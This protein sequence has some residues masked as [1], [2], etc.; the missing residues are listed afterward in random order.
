MPLGVRAQVQF[1][2]SPPEIDSFPVVRSTISV[3]YSGSPA[4]F[5]KSNLSV[6]E[7]GQA[8]TNFE[9]LDCDESDAASIALLV[10]VSESMMFTLWKGS[11]E[12]YN[13]F[14]NFTDQLHA[15][16]EYA[17]IP[18]NDTVSRIIP[19]SYRTQDFFKVG[20]P[21]NL[22]EFIDSI[23]GLQFSGNTDVD[24]AIWR[25]TEHLKRASHSRKAIVLMTD[26]GIYDYPGLVALLKQEGMSLFVL[27]L[28]ADT[29]KGNIVAANE[30]GG[31]FF[32]PR[33]STE[34]GPM[35]TE[36]A[37]AIFAKKCTMRY[38][39]DHPC[40][41]WS[42]KTLWI[43]L[44]YQNEKLAQ[45]HYFSLGPNKRDS[46]APRISE[47]QVGPSSR[48]VRAD[49]DFPCQRG[50]RSFTDSA[51]VNF[52]K[53]SRVR[54]L[55]KFAYDSLVVNDLSQ[56]AEGYYIAT[57]S[58]GNASRIKI[59]YI[60]APDTL[61][62]V[63]SVPFNTAPEQYQLT[64]T[65]FRKHDRGI[66]SIVLEASS[67]NAKLD[68]V[69]YASAR[70]AEV[71]VSRIDY[72]QPATACLIAIDSVGNDSST[73]ITFVVGRSDINPPVIIQ[74]AA[75]SPY[76]AMMADVTELR[77]GD[78]GIRSISVTPISNLSGS[79]IQYKSPFVAEVTAAIADSLYA[80]AAL[81][82][83][84]DSA[85]NSSQK[86][87]VYT[88]LPDVLA[89]AYALDPVNAQR[90]D[91]T[92]SESQ[93]W[94]RGLRSVDVLQSSNISSTQSSFARRVSGWTF[95][96]IDPY[97][98]ATAEVEAQDSAG[99]RTTITITIPAQTPP[100]KLPLSYEDPIDFG[101]VT[102]PALL[103]RSIA[104]ANPD[105]DPVVIA[106]GTWSGDDSIFSVVTPL[107]AAF[108]PGSM[109]NIAFNYRPLLLGDWAATYTIETTNGEKYPIRMKGSSTGLLNLT[110][111]DVA[112]LNA[113]DAGELTLGIEG[114]PDVM[115]LDTLSF[116]L[117]L[118]DDVAKLLRPSTS[119]ADADWFCN[120]S[121]DWS[122]PG[123][124]RYDIRLERKTTERS[125]ELSPSPRLR[126]PF[127]TYLSGKLQT[128]VAVT[129][130][131]ASRATVTSQAGSIA[132][133]ESCGDSI[134]VDRLSKAAT[135]RIE[136]AEV[137]PN[138]E[139]LLGFSS[140]SDQEVTIT[141][142][143]LKG[144]RCFETSRA[145]EQGK[146]LLRMK[147]PD[148]PSGAYQLV[149]TSETGTHRRA[150]HIVH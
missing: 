132:I 148:L 119:C 44:N 69:I 32:S 103:K 29:I 149:I 96:S 121:L 83:A 60:P 137:G 43:G 81:V 7:D 127:K 61:S 136:R 146:N 79:S 88:P 98:I 24:F 15:P 56:P 89:P 87:L 10:D 5:D 122:T 3:E 66:K 50:I 41:W 6:Q 75:V 116:S 147:L 106:G 46:I 104:V 131:F 53:L 71:Y 141:L 139:L 1:F 38:V 125:L 91:L 99:N 25:A 114:T 144:L 4:L 129:N 48:I 107:P 65:E 105:D 34:V 128:A 111:S 17:L 22:S 118:D 37:K 124:G 142:V 140:V 36:I 57:D 42:E 138:S 49:E 47:M 21:N 18:F 80:A 59:T 76:I 12:F 130:V 30:S 68:S 64:A 126:I 77:A 84:L 31:K 73:C 58:N 19:A 28:D 27:E 74:S 67:S 62:P 51:L 14:V 94:D 26:D 145:V 11:D 100:V 39:S 52:A 90:R 72:T 20:D 109:N 134:I 63:W 40:P 13:S 23:G 92:F 95:T 108:A 55:P 110:L 35:M 117:T 78:V 2:T 120:Y 135:T 86:Q 70:L 113:G 82:T 112:V 97:M 143:D 133:G 33:D 101:T 85:G 115:N 93:P 16:T 9:L 8:I 123:S 45:T 102:A 54:A 150:V